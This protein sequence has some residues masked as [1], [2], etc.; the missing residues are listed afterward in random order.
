MGVMSRRRLLLIEQPS[1]AA[2]AALAALIA[3][4]GQFEVDRIAWHSLDV[5]HLQRKGAELVLAVAVPVFPQAMA[6][7]EW[8]R[9]HPTSTLSFVILPAQADEAVLRLAAD[10]ADDFMLWPLRREELEQRVRRM[11]HL[12][13]TDV[14]RA[15]ERIMRELGPSHMVGTDPVFV[16]SIQAIPLA[17]RSGVPALITGETGTGKEL[18]ARAIHHLSKRRAFPFIA[19]DCSALPDLLFENELFGHSRGAYTDAHADQKGLVAIADGGTL[20]LDEIDSLSAASQ[21]KMLRFLQERTFKPLG[22]E[23]FHRADLNIISAS[24]ADLESMVRERQFRADLF[25][26][27]NVLQIRLPALRERRTDIER[28]ACHILRSISFSERSRPRAFSKGALR[29]LQQYDWPG[30]VRELSNI[31]HR[32]ALV[33]EGHRILPDHVALP[34]S[35]AKP[36]PRQ[37]QFRHAKAEAVAAFEQHYVEDLLRKHGG[38]VTRASRVAGTD[39]RAFGRLMKKYSI[40]RRPLAGRAV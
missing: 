10:A 32:A 25:F 12:P 30:N 1:A 5:D 16:Q 14:E 27:L 7:L 28:L 37:Q 36:R 22:G 8:L 9:T 20:F 21:A 2:D 38:N 13:T 3:E 4:D 15:H 11:L 23:R 40:E 29:R 35:T 34:D 17:A 24:N 39:R 19:V 6:W 18:C 33:C 26:R 31:V